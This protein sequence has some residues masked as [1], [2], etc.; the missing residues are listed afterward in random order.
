MLTVA[1]LFTATSCETE[2]VDDRPELP[3][4]ESL[5]M[6]F[7]AFSEEP[8]G[9]KGTSET[10]KNFGYSFVTV[11]AMNILTGAATI[12]PV[13]AYGHAL[14]QTPVYK[15]DYTWEWF[16]DFNANAKTHTV[17]LTGARIDN[18]TFSMEM[19]IDDVKWFDGVIRYDHT[20]A[21]WTLYEQGTTSVLEVEWNKDYVTE[22]A[23]LTYTYTKPDQTETGSYITMAYD[24]EATYDA[25][26]TISGAGGMVYIQ[27]DAMF[28]NGRVKS[29]PFFE[30][31]LW[32]CW[33]TKA[34]NF[35]D[36]EC[37]E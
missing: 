5:Q 9:T 32:H 4:V 6:D 24:P 34:N 37:S 2:P 29:M 15:G 25:S 18:E 26:Y 1:V 21:F 28:I 35:V 12:L 8:A 17:T 30:D 13:L 11:A 16:F 36:I 33:D 10:Y 22:V 19:V 7:S 23:D 27:W 20:N 14:Q 31:D 3:P